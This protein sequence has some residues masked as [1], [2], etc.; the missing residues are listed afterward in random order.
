MLV[1]VPGTVDADTELDRLSG[2][3]VKLNK[4]LAR[5][6]VRF[7][8]GSPDGV[9]RAAFLLLVELCTSGPQR[10]S[11]LAEAVHSEVSTVSR[12]V[13]QLVKLGLVARQ[14]DP[15]DGRASLLAAT[16]AGRETFEARRRLRNQNMAAVLAGWSVSDRH[17][18]CELL[19]RFNRDYEDFHRRGTGPGG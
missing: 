10:L 16:D 9:E 15:D 1:V 8:A 3:L 6:Q 14:P 4:L 11:T 12:Q 17:A 13:N 5:A 7:S 19:G 2:E 18:L